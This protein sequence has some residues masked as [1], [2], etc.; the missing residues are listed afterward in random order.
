LK[1]ALKILYIF[2]AGIGV[3]FIN[4][5]YILSAIIGVHLLLFLV[6]PS[7]EKSLKFLWKVK[8]FVLIIFL[9]HALSGANDIELLK[10]KK[11][12]VA[13]SY[14]GLLRGSIMAS[15]LISMLLITQVVRLTMKKRDFVDGMTRIGLSQ[16]SAEIIDQII[17]IT[18][19]EK[20]DKQRKGHRKS[21][22]NKEQS[23]GNEVRSRD[24]LFKGKV[25]NIPKK[26]LKR[27]DFA[28]DKFANN[29]NAVVASS[30]LS[31]TLI[32]MVK[33][34][35]GLPLAPGHKNILVLPVLIY[36]I[37]KSEKKLAG[38]QIGF[39]SGVLHFT[40]G[41]GKYGPLG[42]LQFAILGWV[43]DLLL[44]LPIKRTNLLFLMFVGGMGGFVRISTEIILAYVLGMPNIFYLLY[45]PY[46][47]S[48]VSFGVASGFISKSIIKPKDE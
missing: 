31:V 28:K 12:T 15:K 42:I 33:I 25:G 47:I 36:G 20:G 37:T 45:L 32:R 18:A 13:L 21:K 30:A 22:K 44:M 27:I 3:F 39:I 7:K 26:L 11:W 4:D 43:I 41:F 48:Q 8:W 17:E 24:V 35:P 9:F 14:D 5:I 1:N 40:M 19:Q 29:P 2:I 23:D 6:Y 10:L 46:I 38:L 34:A 16:S